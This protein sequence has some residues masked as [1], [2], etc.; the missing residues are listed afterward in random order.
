MVI[1]AYKTVYSDPLRT[2]SVSED[3]TVNAPAGSVGN[4]AQYYQFHFYPVGPPLINEDPT[5]FDLGF[6]SIQTSASTRGT[7]NNWAV[8]SCN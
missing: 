6:V 5:N 3:I 4:I 2:E 1:R 8:I 7:N